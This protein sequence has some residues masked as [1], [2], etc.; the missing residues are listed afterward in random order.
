MRKKEGVERG[1]KIREHRQMR[2]ISK[3]MQVEATLRKQREK[4]EMLDEVSFICEDL[5]SFFLFYFIV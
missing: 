4:K 1:E 2:K 3:Q 5:F